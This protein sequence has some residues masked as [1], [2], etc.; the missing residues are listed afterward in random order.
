MASKVEVRED[1]ASSIDYQLQEVQNMRYGYV[2]LRCAKTMH[3]ACPLS[4]LDQPSAPGTRAIG[5]HE[6][7]GKWRQNSVHANTAASRTHVL[8]TSAQKTTRMAAR[9]NRS[10][11][12][13]SNMAMR[14]MNIHDSGRETS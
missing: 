9:E 2:H 4:H 3:R 13:L 12:S 6:Y 1:D 5:V 7:Y 8:E 11:H 14:S 10:T